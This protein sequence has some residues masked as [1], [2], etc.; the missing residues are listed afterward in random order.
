MKAASEITK[1][2][3]YLSKYKSPLTVKA[4]AETLARFLW[5]KKDRELTSK[6]AEEFLNYMSVCGC[7]NRSLNRHL[8]A[9]KAYYG[10]LHS[11]ELRVDGY[12]IGRTL[13]VWL[14]DNEI[15]LYIQAC[16]DSL[17]KALAIT[18]LKSGVRLEELRTLTVDNIDSQGYITVIGKGDKERTIAVP[19]E[20]I[21]V[22]RNWLSERG[23]SA[24]LVFPMSRTTI[25]TRVS[26][27]ARRAGIEK[28]VSPHTLRHSFASAW[29]RHRGK[30]DHLQKQLGHS[31][32]A[33]TSVYLHATPIEIK[34]EMPVI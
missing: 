22:L 5:Y 4:Y 31:N 2:C 23:L 15:N 25:E 29:C 14:T 6:L 11:M 30:L 18:F 27:L 13:P 12:K 24:G 16:S 1:F 32:I 28:K 7:S 20:V 19:D 3:G 34:E 8:A 9:L 10:K 17:E 21:T 33:I 26:M